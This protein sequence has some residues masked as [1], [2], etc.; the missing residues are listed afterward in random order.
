MEYPAK[1][2]LEWIDIRLIFVFS[3]MIFLLVLIFISIFG[4]FFLI[5]YAKTY[6]KH[7]NDLY[8]QYIRGSRLRSTT[9]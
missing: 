9:S 1:G 6:S 4:C 2:S 5:R 7:D 8:V 3:V